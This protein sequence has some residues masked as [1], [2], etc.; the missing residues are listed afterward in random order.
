MQRKTANS[1]TRHAIERAS[2]RGICPEA[3]E[4]TLSYG[5]EIHQPNG[6]FA[7]C[8]DRAAVERARAEGAAISAWVGTTLVVALDGGVVTTLCSRDLRRLRRFGRGQ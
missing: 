2:Q 3:I 8:L 4:A 7:L 1:W 6:R 5:T